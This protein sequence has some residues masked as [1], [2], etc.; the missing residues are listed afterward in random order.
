MRRKIILCSL[1]CLGFFQ[2]STAQQ[3]DSLTV[4]LNAV[5]ISSAQKKLYSE[6][7]RVITVIEKAEI[8]RSSVQ[9]LDQL[10]DYVAGIDIRQRGTNSTQADISVR[11]GS[12]DQ[13]LVLLNGVNITDPQTGHFNLD[14][15]LNLSDIKRIE[16]LEG[17]AARVLGPNAFSGA[18]NI[19]TE[20]S[21]KQ[22]LEAELTG[23]SY[24]TLGQAISGNFNINNISTFASV[25][26]KSS[27][28]YISNTD[29]NYLNGFIQSSVTTT[30]AGK[31]DLQLATQLKDFGA[32]SFY[33]LAYPNQ[34]ESSK[35]FMA[36]LSWNLTKGNWTYKG[37][38][39]W[40]EHHDRF[41]LF[42]NFNNAAA[43][44]TTHNYHM[45]NVTGGK[46]S[47]AYLSL[48]GKTTVGIELRN[49][50]IF[51]N[52]LG[53][54]IDSLKAPLEKN[55]Y[56]TKQANRLTETGL[57]DHSVN[58]GKWY[59][60]LG[61]AVTNSTSFGLN[62]YGGVDI[63][64]A[65]S[66]NFRVFANA[67]SAVRLPTFTD[68]Y[69]KSATQLANPNLLPER[70]QTIEIGTKMVESN[71]KLDAD[72]YYRL[73]QNVIDWVKLPSETIWQSKNLT[74]VNALGGDLSLSYFFEKSFI[75]KISVSYSYLQMNKSADNFDSK[76][77]LD[78]LKN[79]FIA[80][81]SHNIWSN[82][83]ATWNFGYYDRDGAFNYVNKNIQKFE[84]YA[85]VDC[86]LLWV[87]GKVDIFADLNNILN[88][89]YADY[90][91]LGQ[92]G[93][94]FNIGVRKRL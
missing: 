87:N 55:G 23:G 22:S 73:G 13:V 70:S 56:F 50:H 33:S 7:G 72:V 31:F 28:G 68:L 30:N 59:L 41:E 38:A 71:W 51:S 49:E 53:T 15:P 84:P 79:K 63:A 66:E 46:F 54:S 27:N 77:V 88:T 39:Y 52:V 8:T 9:S 57:I 5:E 42:R 3:K 82:L 91:E 65:F 34:Y 64:Y 48:L 37:Q 18:I 93:I 47:V 92:P 67:N 17:S 43:W 12:F 85:L 44:Y 35:T 36:A 25:S 11:G 40:R 83:S 26:H 62:S 32:N 58:I 94:N 75:K 16:V 90:G 2:A 80:S 78:Y 74:N 69:Y 86:R 1:V 10:L 14:V 19:I 20:N 81:I 6:M 24:V 89:K 45:T 29:F 4:D 76:Y 21:E 61:A 60:S